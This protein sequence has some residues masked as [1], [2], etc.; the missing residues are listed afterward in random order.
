MR[1][2]GGGRRMRSSMAVPR[3]PL[4]RA[5]ADKLL[6]AGPEWQTNGFFVARFERQTLICTSRLITARHSVR[7]HVARI[8]EKSR[9][10]S[11]RSV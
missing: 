2:A 8:V 1:A 11:Y 10:V 7:H 3:L 4:L 9:T 6:R 5:R